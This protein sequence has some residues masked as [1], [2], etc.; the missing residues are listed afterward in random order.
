MSIIRNNLDL[1]KHSNT[2]FSSEFCKISKNS[3]LCRTPPT[4]A[5]GLKSNINNANLDKKKL[6]LYFGNSHV[7][8]TNKNL[9]IYC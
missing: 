1:C 2:D 5:S 8:Q 7:N 6:F 4:A 3:F 9:F